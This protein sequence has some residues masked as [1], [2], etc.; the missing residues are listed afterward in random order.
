MEVTQLPLIDVPALQSNTEPSVY[1]C[2]PRV[3]PRREA[4][5]ACVEQDDLARFEG[6]GGLQAP[7]LLSRV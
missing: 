4:T 1:G 7:E 5:V 3:H 2:E 6:E